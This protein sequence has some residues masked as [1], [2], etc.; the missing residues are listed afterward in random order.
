MWSAG[1]GYDIY[2]LTLTAATL[3][4]LQGFWNFFVYIRPRYLKQASSLASRLMSMTFLKGRSRGRTEHVDENR[5]ATN[6]THSQQSLVTSVSNFPIPTQGGTV[7]GLVVSSS[8]LRNES[9]VIPVCTP[10]PITESEFDGEGE[11]TVNP[12]KGVLVAKGTEDDEDIRYEM[13]LTG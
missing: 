2:S 9:E 10:D 8:G 4:P 12:V 7:G 11:N 6:G 1:Y 13:A 3:A 5:Q